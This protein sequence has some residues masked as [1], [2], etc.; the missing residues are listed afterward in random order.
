MRIS[1]LAIALLFA[2]V[3]QAQTP[4]LVTP[5]L[6]GDTGGSAVCA[7]VNLDK[8][9]RDISV[10][11]FNDQGTAL[12]TQQCSGLPSGHSC[13]ASASP[14]PQLVYC[15]VTATVKKQSLRLSIMIVDATGMVTS[16]T[17]A[18]RED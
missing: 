6:L 15:T 14:G 4:K 13:Q 17:A 9:A 3:A 12:N 11:L 18:G 7:G 10:S 16:T 5:P 2:T 8:K 1:L